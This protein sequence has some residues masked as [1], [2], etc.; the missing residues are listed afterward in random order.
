VEK[1]R[2]S[3]RSYLIAAADGQLDTENN[4]NILELID[5]K[6]HLATLHLSNSYSCRRLDNKA[7]FGRFFSAFTKRMRPPF[8][9]TGQPASECDIA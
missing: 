7:R 1:K 3:R 2:E 4:L 6:G 5:F 8:T 9:M